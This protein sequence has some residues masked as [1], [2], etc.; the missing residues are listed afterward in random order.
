MPA[1][2]CGSQDWHRSP[3]A[4]V[5]ITCAWSPVWIVWR[6]A[7][8]ARCGRVCRGQG[9]PPSVGLRFVLWP[10]GSC[11]K[12]PLAGLRHARRRLPSLL[13]YVSTLQDL[14]SAV[15]SPPSDSITAARLAVGDF[16]SLAAFSPTV[17]CGTAGE[18][19]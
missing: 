10:F 3:H 19:T 9:R 6:Q 17:R 5:R 14:Q 16:A 18:T 8:S 1:L 15:G 2:A 4:R 11:G 7:A 12:Q 13:D